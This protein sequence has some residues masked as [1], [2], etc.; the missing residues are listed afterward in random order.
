MVARPYDM[1]TMNDTGGIYEIFRFTNA[2]ADGFFLPVILLVIWILIFM[3]TKQYS[4]SKAWTAASFVTGLLA[5]PLAILEL[6]A[7][8]YMYLAIFLTVAGFL[9]LKLEDGKT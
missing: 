7:P 8:R 9:W 2:Q 1:P 3:A 5:I 4:A 6:I